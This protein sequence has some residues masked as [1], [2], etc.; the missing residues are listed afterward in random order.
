MVGAGN[1]VEQHTGVLEGKFPCPPPYTLRVN[2]S[3]YI[4]SCQPIL[5]F[6]QSVYAASAGLMRNF[7]GPGFVARSCS[8]ESVHDGP[9]GASNAGTK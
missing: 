3:H 8:Q 6:R 5:V 7:I 9:G 1:R 4:N 2:M